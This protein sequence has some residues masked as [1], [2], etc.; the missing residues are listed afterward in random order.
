MLNLIIILLIYLSL[1]ILIDISPM[2]KIFILILL[3]ILGSLI[4]IILDNYYIG[5]TYIIIYVGAIAILFQFVIMMM[6]IQSISSSKYNNLLLF[7]LPLLLPYLLNNDSMILNY[8]NI[9][10]MYSYVKL[11]T[12]NLVSILLYSGQYIYIFIIGIILWTILI[13]ILGLGKK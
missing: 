1:L 6:N 12:I 7:L 5:L 13:G 2:Q 10:W 9:N 8:L 11:Y 4:M 3:Y